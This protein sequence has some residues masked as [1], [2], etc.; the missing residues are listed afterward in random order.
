MTGQPWEARIDPELREWFLSQPPDPSRTKNLY[1]REDQILPC[2]AALAI[3]LAGQDQAP[4]AP[5]TTPPDTSR[6]PPGSQ[7]G[8]WAEAEVGSQQLV[9]R[10]DLIIEQAGTG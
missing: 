1:V 5:G 3:L 6:F 7:A 9:V 10:A 8:A 2:L 4:G